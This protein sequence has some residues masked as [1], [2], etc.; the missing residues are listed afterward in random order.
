MTS[1]TA[2]ATVT[3]YEDGTGE[4]SVGGAVQPIAAT[5]VQAAQAQAM[6]LIVEAARSKR[7]PIEFVAKYRERTWRVMAG[8]DGTVV[9]VNASTAM[10]VHAAT[11]APAPVT[12]A[13]SPLEAAATAA[14]PALPARRPIRVGLVTATGIA[15]VALIGC[16]VLA[17]GS[18]SAIADARDRADT[19]AAEITDVRADL[20]AQLAAAKKKAAD[21]VAA[22]KKAEG[23]AA[24]AQ[25]RATDAAARQKTAEAAQ[26]KAAAQ[27]AAAKKKA[28]SSKDDAKGK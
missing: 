2:Q 16:G 27:L 25:K 15:A 14:A 19:A 1:T 17:I 3:L 21:A 12:V 8:P 28:A 9:E 23:Q 6:E 13:P 11:S 5:D 10:P 20:T 18:H 24:A 7:Q 22:Q 26:K 4:V